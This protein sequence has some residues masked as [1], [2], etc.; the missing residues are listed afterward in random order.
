MGIDSESPVDEGHELEDEE[1]WRGVTGLGSNEL[2]DLDLDYEK[3]VNTIEGEDENKFNAEVIDAPRYAN[4]FQ[5]NQT[6]HVFEEALA[7]LNETGQVPLGYG[8]HPLEWDDDGYPSIGT[9]R[10][11]RKGSKRLEIALPDS[12]W[13]PRSTRWVQGLYLMNQLLDQPL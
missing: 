9:I 1:E 7:R 5:D 13:R 6:C 10:V 2:E 12:V 8:L 4:P 11:G 3:L